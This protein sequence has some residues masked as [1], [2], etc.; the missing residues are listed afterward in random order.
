MVKDKGIPNS[1][2][3]ARF[4][5]FQ[6]CFNKF[7]NKIY[8]PSKHLQ[9]VNYEST[10]TQIACVIIAKL[11]PMRQTEGIGKVFVLSSYS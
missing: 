10:I 4:K 1:Q 8:I 9:H 2:Q 5:P 3:N 7:I 11:S 6:S